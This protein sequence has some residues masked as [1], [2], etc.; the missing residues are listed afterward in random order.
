MTRHRAGRSWDRGSIPGEGKI[1]FFL[2]R[3]PTRLLFSG[4]PEAISPGLAGLAV[5]AGLLPPS[6]AGVKNQ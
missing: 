1:F 2:R 4:L 3:D 5:E 6:S